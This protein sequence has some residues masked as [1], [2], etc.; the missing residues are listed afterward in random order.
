MAVGLN[1]NCQG[2]LISTA[3]CTL[4]QWYMK[5]I[6]KC[7]PKLTDRWQCCYDHSGTAVGHQCD[8][9]KVDT[10]SQMFWNWQKLSW[11]SYMGTYPPVLIIHIGPVTYDTYINITSQRWPDGDNVVRTTWMAFENTGLLT[12]WPVSVT[13]GQQAMG[14]ENWQQNQ[15]LVWFGLV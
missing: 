4:S 5:C 11:V 1:K 15:Q 6:L 3:D 7:Q 2:P 14:R 9:N 12:R 10:D 13:C 8:F